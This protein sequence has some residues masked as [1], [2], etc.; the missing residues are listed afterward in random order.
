MKHFLSQPT[1]SVARFT[2]INH[3]SPWGPPSEPPNNNTY[4]LNNTIFL[5]HYLSGLWAI[6]FRFHTILP[7]HF[8]FPPSSFLPL[9]LLIFS[10]LPSE[11]QENWGIFTMVEEVTSPEPFYDTIYEEF[12]HVNTPRLRKGSAKQRLKV[13]SLIFAAK[14]NGQMFV[15]LQ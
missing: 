10:F 13:F 6:M 12:D 4:P 9:F 8:F 14:L 2:Y 15:K 1:L 5:S 7:S 3:L 11:C